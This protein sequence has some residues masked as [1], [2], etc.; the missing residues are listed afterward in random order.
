MRPLL[1]D[2]II[3]GWN[4][5]MNTACSKAFAATGKE[6]YKELAIANMK[7]LLENFASD[8][9]DE[10]YHTWKNGHA[11]YPAFLDD[12]AF[13][14]Q[15]LIQLQEITGDTEW[16]TRAKAITESV[17]ENFGEPDTGFFFYTRA[18]QE[19]VIVRKKEIYDGAVPS[20]NAVMAIILY[21]LSIYFDKA[22]WRHRSSQMLISLGQALSRYPTSF[23]CWDCLLLEVTKGT[24]EIAIVG[25]Q[26]H[27]IHK[28]L[29]GEFIPNKVIMASSIENEQFVLLSGKTATEIPQIYV[30]KDFSCLKPVTSVAETITYINGRKELTNFM[31]IQ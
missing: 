16:L 27:P 25:R 6:D 5:L 17:I 10:F 30:C 20:G 11:K 4:A 3:L 7:F 22:D 26:F 8:K 21:Q 15:A 31:L 18:D 9:P 28:E 1:D 12:Y 13:L 24:V 29:L 14:I 19:D 2:K 23:G